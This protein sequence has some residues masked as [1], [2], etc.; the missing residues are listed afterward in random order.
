MSTSPAE[1]YKT[2]YAD[3]EGWWHATAIDTDRAWMLGTF[4]ISN[5]PEA[6]LSAVE[7]QNGEGLYV[8]AAACADTVS[9]GRTTGEDARLIPF[10]W[11]DADAV[12]GVHKTD[13]GLLRDLGHLQDLLAGFPHSPTGVV[14]T[15]GGWQLFWKLAEPIDAQDDGQLWLDRWQT[16][17][18]RIADEAGVHLDNTADRARLLRM[19]GSI[20]TKF[21]EGDRPTVKVIFLDASR[22]YGLDDFDEVLDMPEVRRERIELSCR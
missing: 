9:G 7:S 3:A 12:H 11:L 1:F 21:P 4:P 18:T 15:G 19:V 13:D 22:Q 20:N 8:T 2:M 5:G 6:M 10:L 17:W 16:T 14:D